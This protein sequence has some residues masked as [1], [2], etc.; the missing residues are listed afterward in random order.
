MGG[1][2]SFEGLAYIKSPDVTRDNFLWVWVKEQVN[3]LT[4]KT[5]HELEYEIC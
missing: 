5:L 4:P 3:K 1:K 2:L